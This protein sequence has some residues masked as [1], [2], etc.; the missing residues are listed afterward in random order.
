MPL[1]TKKYGKHIILHRA[2]MA[3][4]IA[5]TFQIMGQAIDVNG[6][7]KTLKMEQLQ[8]MGKHLTLR[9]RKRLGISFKL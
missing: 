8:K 5:P 6:M 3:L 4:Y 1:T 9:T 2:L 7:S